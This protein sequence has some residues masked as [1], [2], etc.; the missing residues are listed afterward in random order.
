MN[1][2]DERKESHHLLH[3]VAV[4]YGPYLLGLLDVVLGRLKLVR[5]GL[6]LCLGG[7]LF[8]L[9]VEQTS[10]DVLGEVSA[11]KGDSEITASEDKSDGGGQS[12]D[13]ERVRRKKRNEPERFFP[14]DLLL[15]MTNVLGLHPDLVHEESARAKSCQTFDS[16]EARGEGDASNLPVDLVELHPVLP[17]QVGELDLQLTRFLEDDSL[18]LVD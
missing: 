14:L 8:V 12:E 17:R 18:V 2:L 1:W 13:R 11:S 4:T 10:L 3:A 15:T 7:E 6:K 5:D 16:N 9:K